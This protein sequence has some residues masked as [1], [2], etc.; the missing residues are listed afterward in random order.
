MNRLNCLFVKL[1]NFIILAKLLKI[2]EFFFLGAG[3]R[4]GGQTGSDK[5]MEQGREQFN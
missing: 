2:L 4:M 5:L 3:G 1:R